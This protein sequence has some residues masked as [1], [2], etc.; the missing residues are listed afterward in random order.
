[1]L[2]GSEKGFHAIDTETEMKY[3]LYIPSFVS[4]PIIP[5]QILII[6]S[7]EGMQLLLCYND[8]GVYVDTFG[9]VTKVTPTFKR[10]IICITYMYI[11]LG[12][13]SELGRKSTF[14]ESD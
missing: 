12:V 13:H 8:E 6:P 14:G 11:I 9:R 3:D 5:H 1:M 7:T 10:S 2:Y 4:P